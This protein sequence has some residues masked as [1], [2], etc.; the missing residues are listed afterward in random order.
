MSS[1]L[2]SICIPTYNG[3]SFLKR[4]LDSCLGQTYQDL[5]IIVNDD[6]SS[7]DTKNIVK[8]YEE[9]DKRI[10]FS[11]NDQNLGL[12]GNWNATLNKATGSWIKILFQDDFMEPNCIEEMMSVAQLHPGSMVI[13][14]RSYVFDKEAPQDVIDYYKNKVV[15]LPASNPE[16]ITYFTTSEIAELFIQ[17]IGLNFIAEPSLVFFSKE[18]YRRSGIFDPDFLQVCDLE[19]TLRIASLSGIIYLDKPLVHFA[20]HMCSTTS[21]NVSKNNFRIRFF[22]TPILINKINVKPVF[23]N[24]RKAFGSGDRL[25]LYLYTKLRAIEAEIVAGKN[26]EHREQYAD[27]LNKY[28]FMKIKVLERV[29]LFPLFL[30]AKRRLTK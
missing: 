26:K 2:V 29:F 16:Q 8:E 18:M 17:N 6:C 14:K 30:Y 7:D 19:H 11:S 28:P 9:K 5:E 27:L 10:K 4:S 25:K 1:G 12:V 21:V 22:E 13:S 24:L 23:D 15:S 3:S 20:V